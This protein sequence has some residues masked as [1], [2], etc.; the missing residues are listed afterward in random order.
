[1]PD[2]SAVPP[3]PPAPNRLALAATLLAVAMASLDTAVVNTA[4]PTIAADLRIAPAQAVWV[5]N[6]YQLAMVAL[7][8]PFAALGDWL[9]PRR[10]CLGGLLGF[11]VSSAACALADGRWRSRARCRA[12]PPRR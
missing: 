4:L 10:V 8:L 6:A 9:G 11:L 1:M 5:I 7:L 2:S 3:G 12:S